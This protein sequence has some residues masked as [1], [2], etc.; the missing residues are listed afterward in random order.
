MIGKCNTGGENVTPEVTTQTP[1]IQNITEALVGKAQGATAT[2]DKILEGYSAYV[3]GVLVDGEYVPHGSG[4]YAWKKYNYVPEQTV[5]FD[6]VTITATRPDKSSVVFAS[7]DF[8]ITA[9]RDAS[10]FDGLTCGTPPYTLEFELNSSGY[11]KVSE[12]GAGVGAGSWDWSTGTLSFSGSTS[13]TSHGSG[14]LNVSGSKTL[15]GYISDFND[16]CVSDNALDYPNGAVHTDG[17]WYE[18]ITGNNIDHGTITITDTKVNGFTVP[19]NLKAIPSQIFLIPEGNVT[20]DTE[21]TTATGTDLY[22]WCLNQLNPF[23]KTGS[24]LSNNETITFQKDS[25]YYFS[26]GTT[27]HWFAL[28]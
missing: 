16:Y 24:I 2:A 9:I 26:K 7:S 23:L 15:P 17:Y 5:N 25:G 19:H 22:M 20:S 28:A 1:I 6:N 12:N 10:F 8:D 21:F 27:Y 11:I 13:S 14:N 3:G 4:S 18:S